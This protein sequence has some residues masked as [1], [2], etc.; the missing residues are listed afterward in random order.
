MWCWWVCGQHKC[1]LLPIDVHNNHTFLQC[2][3]LIC[4]R[5]LPLKMIKIHPILRNEL[6]F[7][8][9]YETYFEE[10]NSFTVIF[11]LCVRE[12]HM[13]VHLSPNH[14]ICGVTLM[15]KSLR[16]REENEVNNHG[17]QKIHHWGCFFLCSLTKVMENYNKNKWYSGSKISSTHIQGSK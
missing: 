6:T 3:L 14:W 11:L 1:R 16:K 8:K 10:S 12:I 9:T 17:M 2:L 15:E 5:Q 7:Q 13:F 4:L